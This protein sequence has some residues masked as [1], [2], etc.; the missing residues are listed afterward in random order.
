MGNFDSSNFTPFMK[1]PA[2]SAT[3]V[4]D[5]EDDTTTGCVA[6]NAFALLLAS[7]LAFLTLLTM[8]SKDEILSNI[9]PA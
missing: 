9:V 4:D 3:Y 5:D 1:F 7:T 2:R 8:V 6:S